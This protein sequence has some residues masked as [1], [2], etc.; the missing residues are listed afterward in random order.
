MVNHPVRAGTAFCGEGLTLADRA[1]AERLRLALKV[2]M[3]NV[4]DMT[5]WFYLS[6]RSGVSPTT[7]ENWIYGR[8]VPQASALAK[9]GNAL[10]PW[11]TPAKLEAAYSGVEPEEP[12]LIDALREIIPELHE[13]VILLRAQADES[14]L[15]AVRAAL[16]ES[17]QRRGEAPSPSP[18]PP[19]D[20]TSEDR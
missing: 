13:L 19:A 12:P 20:Q 18:V 1:S 5:S 14:V 15:V 10:R 17:R 7:I 3:A 9:V 6:Q 11:T 16:E 8:T 2:A 4:P